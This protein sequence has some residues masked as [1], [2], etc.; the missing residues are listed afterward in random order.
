MRFDVVDIGSSELSISERSLQELFLCAAI[1]RGVKR[2]VPEASV[3]EQC[4]S[5]GVARKTRVVAHR[6]SVVEGD[7]RL[8]ERGL[9]GGGGARAE[10]RREAG[11]LVGAV[12]S[13]RAEALAVGGVKANIGHAEPAAGMTGLLKL[14]LGLRA[15]EAAPN[16]QLRL[17]NPHVGAALRPGRARMPA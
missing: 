9:A 11:S 12:L 10:E 7:R 6:E 5:V 4:R 15:S 14:A 13:A 16:A 3:G 17:L 8:A 1:G 2:P